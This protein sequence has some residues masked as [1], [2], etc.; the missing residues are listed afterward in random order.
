M[1]QVVIGRKKTQKGLLLKLSLLLFS[2]CFLLL[3]LL[4]LL[5]VV[6]CCCCCFVAAAVPS[7]QKHSQYGIQKTSV[8]KLPMSAA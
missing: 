5:L 2:F 3:L 6:G 1:K 4:L 7:K 8:L